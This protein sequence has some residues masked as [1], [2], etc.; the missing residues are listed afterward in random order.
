MDNIQLVKLILDNLPAIT[1]ALVAIAAIIKALKYRGD[2]KDY[3]TKAEDMD[4][5][6]DIMSDAI[7]DLSTSKGT[8][9]TRLGKDV[10][11][12]PPAVQRAYQAKKMAVRI[13]KGVYPRTGGIN[14]NKP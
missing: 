7:E 14:L 8:L 3:K 12:A 2:A 4:C 13:R 6:A 5:V 10:A 1:A 11:K 9:R